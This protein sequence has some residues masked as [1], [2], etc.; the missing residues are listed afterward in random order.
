MPEAWDSEE[1]EAS[2][3]TVRFTARAPFAPDYSQI[4]KRVLIIWHTRTMISQKSIHLLQTPIS[5][6]GPAG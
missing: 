1:L 2:M 5:Y 6:E 3:Q 4:P